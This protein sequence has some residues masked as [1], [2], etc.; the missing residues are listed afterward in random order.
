M[1]TFHKFSDVLFCPYRSC[2]KKFIKPLQLT[3]TSKILRETY[4]ACPHCHSKID[5]VVEEFHIIRVE[6]CEGGEKVLSTTT[7]PHNFGYLKDLHENDEIPDEC[8]LCP[9]ILQCSIRK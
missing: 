2:K 6:K 7:C 5:I 8:L 9:K 4:Y 3:D 1:K